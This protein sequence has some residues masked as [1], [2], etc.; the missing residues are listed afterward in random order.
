[1]P[2]GNPSTEHRPSLGQRIWKDRTINELLVQ[3]RTTKNGDS[4]EKATHQGGHKLKT[5]FSTNVSPR[6][7]QTVEVSV[8]LPAYNEERTIQQAVSDTIE[9]LSSFLPAGRYEI[10]II[11]DGCDDRTPELAWQMAEEDNRI[12]H[13]HS[14]KRLDKGKALEQAFNEAS[15]DILVYFDTDVATDLRYLKEL[16]ES[17]RSGEHDIAI[18]SRLIRD[19]EAERP[20]K[21]DILSRGYNLLARLFLRSPIR[22]HQCGFKAFDQEV[23]DTLVAEVEATHWFWDTEVL[24][25]AQ[26]AGYR[27]REFPVEWSSKEDSAVHPAPAVFTMGSQLLRL[28]WQLSVLPRINPSEESR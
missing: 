27:I 3:G 20:L 25:R 6:E 2:D 24:V 16:V 11:E 21:R 5:E 8:V 26:Y 17:V 23:I 1:M 22:D 15:G 10:I 19:F 7:D 9:T 18:G 13:I 4:E 14:S 12:Q 28:W